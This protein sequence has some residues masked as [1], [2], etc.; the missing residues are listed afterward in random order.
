[1][2]H[3]FRF[4]HELRV[5]YSEIDGQNI[6]FNAHYLTYLD[7]AITEYFRTVFGKNWLNDPPEDFDIALVRSTLEFQKPA[8][9]DD[10]LSIWVKVK[11]MGNS[12]FTVDFL[13]TRKGEEDV[14]LEAEQ[15]HVN[16]DARAGK[17]VPIP[18]DIRSLI[19]AFEN[20]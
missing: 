16:F 8:R 11:K 14:L 7:V 17:A 13:M 2:N 3:S 20:S 15:V 5:R 19:N 10:L 1:M 6:V 18:E 12:S 9:L 4:S